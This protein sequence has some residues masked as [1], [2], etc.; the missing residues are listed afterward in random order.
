[1]IQRSSCVKDE[2]LEAHLFYPG[3]EFCECGDAVIDD[4]IDYGDDE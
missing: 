2:Y 1:M 4:R 3:E